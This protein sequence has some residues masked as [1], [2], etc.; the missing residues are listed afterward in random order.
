M[1]WWWT[2]TREPVA[3]PVVVLPP[4]P[5]VNQ[6][7]KEKLKEVL[8]ILHAAHIT[9]ARPASRGYVPDSLDASR[10]IQIDIG[11]YTILDPTIA[12]LKATTEPYGGLVGIGGNNNISTLS[13]KIFDPYHLTPTTPAAIVAPPPSTPWLQ[14]LLTLALL[15]SILYLAHLAGH[16]QKFHQLVKQMTTMIATHLLP[17]TTTP[18]PPPP[19]ESY[20]L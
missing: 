7:S 8:R 11:N 19:E 16:L 10:T 9:G 3:A 4:L 12:L 2:S 17:T 1:L 18:P 13:Y 20:V 5:D 6:Y 15:L 14:L